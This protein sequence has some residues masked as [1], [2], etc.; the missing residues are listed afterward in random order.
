MAVSQGKGATRDAALVSA[1]MEAIELHHAEDAVPAPARTCPGADL[2]LGYELGSLEMG[3]GSLVTGHTVLDWIEARGAVTGNRFLVPRDLVW[4]GQR[5]CGDWRIAMIGGTSN[6][7]AAGNTRAE[8]VAHACY[9][10]AERDAGAALA[11]TPAQQRRV[12]GPGHGAGRLVRRAGSPDPRRRGVAGGGSRA[13]AA[14]ACPVSPPTCG[15]K[16]PP[17]RWRPAREPTP[18]RRSR[19]PGRSPRRRNPA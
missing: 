14:S 5:T 11:A 13:R 7:M 6:G 18:I 8:A 19:C 2:D 16:I 15:R 12:P 1:A 4:L 3:P 10:L 9:E 17:P